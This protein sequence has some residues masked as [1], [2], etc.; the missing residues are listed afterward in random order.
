MKLKCK[1]NGKEYDAVQ[2]IPFSDE[3]NETLDSASIIIS[4]VEKIDNIYP[5]DDVFFYDN[6]FN[7]YG[8]QRKEYKDA[9]S[10]IEEQE[11][12]FWFSL[13]IPDE[14]MK[15][16][17]ERKQY[18][19]YKIRIVFIQGDEVDSVS[20]YCDCFITHKNN[21]YYFE[22]PNIDFK[23]KIVKS[24]DDENFWVLSTLSGNS[25]RIQDYNKVIVE[26]FYVIVSYNVNN[27][28]FY[29]HLLIDDINREMI[30]LEDK[31]LY[32]YNILL[33]SE[34]KRLETIPLPN[35]S[36]TQPLEID[37][38]KS[39]Y[40]YIVDIVDMYSPIYKIID[41]E[42]FGTWKYEKKYIVDSSLKEIFGDVYSPDF[43]LNNPNLR[44]VLSQLMIVKDMIPYVEDDVIKAMDITERKGEFNTKGVNFIKSNLTSNNFCTSL[45]RTYSDALSE[46]KSCRLTEYLSFRNSDN[47]L[48]TIDNMRL[49]TTYPIYKINKM[50]MCYYKKFIIKTPDQ[51]DEVKAFLCKQDITKLV[52]L[53]SE[54][55]V[56]SEDWSKFNSINVK[57]VEDLSKFK[58]GTIGYDIGNKYIDG[59]GTK[60]T[61]Y[62]L[63]NWFPSVNTYAQKILYFMDKFYPYG[64]YNYSFLRDNSRIS[65]EQEIEMIPYLMNSMVSPL[66]TKTT[67]TETTEPTLNPASLKSL[68][69]EVE[70]ESFYNGTIY[71]SKDNLNRD[72][73]VVNDNSSSSLTLLEQDGIMQKEK[74]NR[75]G[76]EVFQFNARYEDISDLQ[77]LGSVYNSKDGKDTDIIIYSREYAIQDNVINCRYLG[78]K[79][80]VLKNYFTSV[81]AKHRPYNLMSYDES[82]YRSENKK[83]YLLLDLDKKVI[84]E[85]K[86][87]LVFKNFGEEY[88]AEAIT[89]S[90]NSI[91]KLLSFLKQTLVNQKMDFLNYDKINYGFYEIKGK[92]YVSDVNVFT[93]A[94]SLC[95]NLKMYDNVSAGV[96]IDT[97]N[98]EPFESFGDFVTVV[99]D[100][101]GSLQEWYLTVDNEKTG[102]IEKMSFYVGHIDKLRLIPDGIISDINV[103]ADK[104]EKKLNTLKKEITENGNEIVVVETGVDVLGDKT[105]YKNVFDLPKIDVDYN[106]MT[107]I[108]GNEYLL[109]KDN[110]ELIDMTF[111]IEPITNSDK[112]LFSPWLMKLSDLN[113]N[114]NKF[115]SPVSVSDDN[116]SGED[117]KALVSIPMKTIEGFRTYNPGEYDS[118]NAPIMILS[119]KK[120]ELNVEDSVDGF[121][122]EKS[123]MDNNFVKTSVNFLFDKFYAETNRYNANTY[124]IR[125]LKYDFNRIVGYDKE[126]GTI[127]LEGTQFMT[128]YDYKWYDLFEW[129]KKKEFSSSVTMKF[130]K[131]DSIMDRP[132][133]KP[134][135]DE[136]WFA[137]DTVSE[138]VYIPNRKDNYKIEYECSNGKYLYTDR[139][140]DES[141]A[142]IV[143]TYFLGTSDFTYYR[144]M[145]ITTSNEPMKKH[146]VYNQY[147]NLE[148]IGLSEDN[149]GPLV[150]DVFYFSDDDVLT[151][152]LYQ[153]ERD[154]ENVKSIQLW[155]RDEGGALNFV[156]GVNVDENDFYKR[157]LDIHVSLIT[158]K[159]MRVFDELHNEI[160]QVKNVANSEDYTDLVTQKYEKYIEK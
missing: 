54:R 134:L 60:Y 110:K 49:E 90:S 138:D 120:N 96:Y 23:E 57:K 136:V 130:K 10:L 133:M 150:S 155:Y 93:S 65:A 46:Q 58:I 51:P 99:D 66:P 12:D 145:F 41:N 16:L 100:V 4:Q 24:P 63:F 8:R 89:K 109:K 88:V 118:K 131:I 9:I 115:F 84:E 36:I 151:V 159:D 144:N 69:F 153:F 2:G 22:I 19:E 20:K 97:K 73:I 149:T 17:F 55:N 79:D 91:W 87:V 70:Y 111:Q 1:I 56:L 85:N 78:A 98:L 13:N 108:I 125:K 116:N 81:Y 48:L 33:C 101:K 5:Y 6:E 83:V 64:I 37:L 126:N 154:K 45:K 143:N 59:W 61:S 25:I 92:K 18:F 43:T 15:I 34:T 106:D 95:F 53:S 52:K 28:K 148:E 67:S 157:R 121:S 129:A 117:E 14:L 86:N 132:M 140:L 76:N 122:L 137:F 135:E 146:H 94:D 29:K 141:N 147:K 160:G 128:Y 105:I 68:V 72:D 158:K 124:T 71:H 113:G 152:D 123:L 40:N 62:F 30:R 47:A 119:I 142:E 104:S 42:E 35:F 82:V 74:I 75:F 139:L 26:E 32:Q 107:N 7:G 3:Y 103:I 39:V 156:F 21:N 44:D 77:E 127:E 38:K 102:F 80:Y 27:N 114:Y 31:T 11:G 112:I 50:Y